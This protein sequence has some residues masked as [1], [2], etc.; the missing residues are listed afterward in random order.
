[1]P[2]ETPIS[3]PT[4]EGRARAALDDKN[5]GSY[6]SVANAIRAAE[7]VAV[8]REREACASML[9]AARQRPALWP[10]VGEA[11]KVMAEAIRSRGRVLA[12]LDGLS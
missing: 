2:G 12:E 10:H 7:R 1:M 11:L 9:D 8:E 5:G 6:E 3:D 4:P